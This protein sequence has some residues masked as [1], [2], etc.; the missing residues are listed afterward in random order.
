M[1][2]SVVVV[3]ASLLVLVGAVARLRPMHRGTATLAGVAA[4]AGAAVLACSEA[5]WALEP[6][7]WLLV[8]SLAVALLSQML[9]LERVDFNDERSE[10]R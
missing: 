3:V 5:R 10:V 4:V 1:N 7:T 9:R 2:S 8:V 6:A